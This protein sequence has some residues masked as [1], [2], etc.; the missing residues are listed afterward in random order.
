MAIEH[1]DDDDGGDDDIGDDLTTHVQYASINNQSIDFFCFFPP[2]SFLPL[3]IDLMQWRSPPINQGIPSI[4]WYKYPPDRNSP[5]HSLKPRTGASLDL[6]MPE[7]TRVLHFS[8]SIG[9]FMH[10]LDPRYV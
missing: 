3:C 1:D 6:H 4:N 8:G 2:I 10:V 7:S 5:S 9:I